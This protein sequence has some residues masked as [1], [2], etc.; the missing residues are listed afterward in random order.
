MEMQTMNY[1][2]TA[3]GTEERVQLKP[4][5]VKVVKVAVQ[6]VGEKNAKKL[7][8]EVKHPAKAELI[9]VSAAKT[10]SKGKLDVN[11]LWVNLDSKELIRK[12]STLAQLLN[13][14]NAKNI[15]EL[16]GKEIDTVEDEN[17]YLVFK[18]Y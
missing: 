14:T 11:G 8:C 1:E 10:E 3:I 17:G 18:A 15:K 16:E 7:I 9:K 6:A 12:G 4:T 13:F 5:K 2:T